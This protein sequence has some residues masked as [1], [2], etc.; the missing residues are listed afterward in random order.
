VCDGL[1]DLEEQ[2]RKEGRKR[3]RPTDLGSGESEGGG[4]DQSRIK[5]IPFVCDSFV[6]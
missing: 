5:Q 4:I 3:R 1:L 2:E 6:C